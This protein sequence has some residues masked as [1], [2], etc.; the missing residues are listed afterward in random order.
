MAKGYRKRREKRKGKVRQHCMGTLKRKENV[1]ESRANERGHMETRE[2][3]G[4]KRM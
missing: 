3:T 1:G 2:G 4:G